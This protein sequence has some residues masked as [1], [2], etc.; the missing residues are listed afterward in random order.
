MSRGRHAKP[1]ATAAVMKAAVPVAAAIG[2]LVTATPA[3]GKPPARP[4]GTTGTTETPHA[5]AHTQHVV[6][7]RYTVQPGD[8]L[9]SIAQRFYGDPL[10]WHRIYQAN[11]DRI[12]DPNLIYAGQQLTIPYGALSGTPAAEPAPAQGRSSSS[13]SPVSQGGTLGCGGLERLWD[14]AS[15]SPA[16][17]FTAA[18]VAMAESG[19]EQYATGGV[20][21]R[22]YWQINPDHGSL[23]TYD[24]LGNARA[25]VAISGNGTDWAP[26]TTYVSGAYQGR[27]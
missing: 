22:G 25:A 8:T 9:T 3:H 23:S 18:E 6:Q 26:W 27:C 17:A 24:A 15:G 12:S 11:A 1:S 19:G 10:K 5:D 21:E 20:G 7:R 14:S 13:S 4:A 16:A 2:T